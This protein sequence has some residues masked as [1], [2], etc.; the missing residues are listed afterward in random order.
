MITITKISKF[1]NGPDIKLLYL[2]SKTFN[3]KKKSK[4]SYFVTKASQ[5]QDQ[6]K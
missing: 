3:R 1:Q 5:K 4:P 6:K 2:T